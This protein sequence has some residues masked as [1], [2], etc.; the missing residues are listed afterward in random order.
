M[1]RSKDRLAE[2]IFFFKRLLSSSC[3]FFP[4]KSPLDCLFLLENNLTIWVKE[5]LKKKI[6]HHLAKHHHV[7]LFSSNLGPCGGLLSPHCPVSYHT[8]LVLWY[9]KLAQHPSQVDGHPLSAAPGPGSTFSSLGSDPC[10]LCVL[11]L[12]SSDFW[13]GLANVGSTSQNS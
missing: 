12:M 5:I 13:L 10:G 1:F 7:F 11:A 4:E 9:I 8:N 6:S 3:F 2:W